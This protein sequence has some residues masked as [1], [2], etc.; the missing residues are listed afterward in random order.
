MVLIRDVV[1]QAIGKRYLTIEAEEQLRRLLALPS[2][3][4]DLKR[5]MHLQQVVMRGYVR[6]ESRELIGLKHRSPHACY[7]IDDRHSTITTP[8]LE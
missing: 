7:S 3:A 5:F 2:D 8:V 6:Q 4:E 1:Q